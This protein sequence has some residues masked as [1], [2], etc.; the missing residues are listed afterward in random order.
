[1]E[2]IEMAK[3]YVNEVKDL[4]DDENLDKENLS[5]EVETKV[6]ESTKKELKAAP[7]K[8]SGVARA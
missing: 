4:L 6:K 1:M 2:E 8:Y 5:Q 7:K 3:K